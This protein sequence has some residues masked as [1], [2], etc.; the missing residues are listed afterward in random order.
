MALVVSDNPGEFP[1][2]EE[3][4][5]DFMY[6]RLHG[7]EVLYQG[8]YSDSA[9]DRWARR[10][11]DWSRAGDVYVFFDNDADGHAPFDARR[12][13]ERLGLGDGLPAPGIKDASNT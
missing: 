1:V 2:L 10:I 8:R 5:T 11:D 4:T 12:L 3:T 13:M 9:L 7:P 6:V